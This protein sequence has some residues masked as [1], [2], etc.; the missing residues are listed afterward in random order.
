MAATPVSICS[1]AL[2]RLGADPI[3]SFDESDTSGANLDRTRVV[4]NLWETVRKQT[5]RSHS[6]NCATKRVLLSPDS[7]A[8]AFGFTNRFLLPSDWLK[9]VQFGEDEAG[10]RYSWRSEGRYLLANESS[11]PIVYIYDNQTCAEWDSQL[12]AAAE[13]AMAFAACYAITKSTSLKDA[14]GAE[15]KTLLQQARTSDGMDD[16]PETLGDSILL[17][18][19]YGGNG[20]GYPNRG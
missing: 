17:A 16:P 20:F 12:V 7:T 11:F 6:W 4:S 1:N 15:L 3:S 18:S 8:P 9:T 14:L 13:I 2:V 10:P 19:R 5:L